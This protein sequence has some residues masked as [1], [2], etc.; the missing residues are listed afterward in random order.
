MAVTTLDPKPAL[1]VIDLQKGLM[2]VPTVHPIDKVVDRAARLA[3]AFADMNCRRHGHDLPGRSGRPVV[4][5][6]DR[7]FPHCFEGPGAHLRYCGIG[8]KLVF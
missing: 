3:S 7:A 8:D 6:Q 1:V 5:V 4:G 2:A